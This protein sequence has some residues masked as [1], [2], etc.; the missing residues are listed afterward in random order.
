MSYFQVIT[1]CFITTGARAIIKVK[2]HQYRWLVGGYDLETGHFF[3]D[4][5]SMVVTWWIVAFCTVVFSCCMCSTVENKV[6]SVSQ[7]FDK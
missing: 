5:A 4:V 3:L 2:G 6:I 1:T 7:K